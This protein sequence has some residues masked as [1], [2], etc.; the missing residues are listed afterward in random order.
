MTVERISCIRGALRVRGCEPRRQRASRRLRRRRYSW[1]PPQKSAA[2]HDTVG[3]LNSRPSKDDHRTGALQ[4]R[5][6]GCQHSTG[7]VGP[8][9]SRP[10]LVRHQPS[11]NT[12]TSPSDSSIRKAA[13][14]QRPPRRTSGLKLK[15][16]HGGAAAV[17]AAAALSEEQ[18]GGGRCCQATR[19]AR[20]TECVDG[21]AHLTR[22]AIG[23]FKEPA[24]PACRDRRHSRPLTV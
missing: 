5:A 14:E 24:R 16:G 17:D 1:D 18:R 20:H 19:S 12:E 7:F 10:L 22:R 3:H 9:I 2:L 8:L 23:T 21:E 13:P 15:R 11:S 6:G 4:T